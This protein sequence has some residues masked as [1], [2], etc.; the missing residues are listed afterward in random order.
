M[1][2][3]TLNARRG[4]RQVVVTYHEMA[5]TEGLVADLVIGTGAVTLYAWRNIVAFEAYAHP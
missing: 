5:S 1:A 2:N 3:D 4:G